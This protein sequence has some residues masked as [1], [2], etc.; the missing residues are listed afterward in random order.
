VTPILEAADKVA[1]LPS[2]EHPP[3]V[4]RFSE[5]DRRTQREVDVLEIGRHVEL[6]VVGLA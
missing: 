6:E 2:E 5:G 3:G 1:V 4:S